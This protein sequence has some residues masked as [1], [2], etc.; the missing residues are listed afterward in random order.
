M[1]NQQKFKEIRYNIEA[2]CGSVSINKEEKTL[3][4]RNTLYGNAVYDTKKDTLRMEDGTLIFN[5]MDW[6]YTRYKK[7]SEH[8][9]LI[10]YTMFLED[11]EDGLGVA[12]GYHIYSFKM[13]QISGKDPDFILDFINHK[14]TQ[15]MEEK[16]RETGGIPKTIPY[17][18]KKK[19][20]RAVVDTVVYEN[21]KFKRFFVPSSYIF[22][23]K[24]TKDVLTKY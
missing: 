18:P 16:F 9:L 23:G 5:G 4:I 15:G 8:H 12:K 10:N 6:L 14:I 21:Q 20:V 22:V 11:P 13:P 1:N 2:L 24:R 17:G 3:E 19:K 7:G